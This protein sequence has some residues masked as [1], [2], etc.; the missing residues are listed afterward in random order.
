M[1]ILILSWQNIYLPLAVEY[2]KRLVIE[3][4]VSIFKY[5]YYFVYPGYTSANGWCQSWYLIA[6]L[7]GLP[8]FMGIYKIC[9]KKV[10]LLILVCSV[11][12]IYYI[13][14]NEFSFLTHLPVWG[15]L[16]FPRL[17]I[18]ILIG[19]ILSKNISKIEKFNISR[20][21]LY[22]IIFFCMFM[23]ENYLVKVNG[24]LINSE[25][26][27]T[28]VPTSIALVL[29]SLKYVPTIKMNVIKVRNCS[30]FIYCAQKYPLQVFLK[31]MKVFYLNTF[32]EHIV[33][34]GSVCVISIFLF[35]IYYHFNKK[36]K[37]L[38]YLV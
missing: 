13:L 15:T 25:E 38:E 27:I 37:F 35:L 9:F 14:A 28:T 8:V 26:V 2:F 32:L 6:M 34:F 20:V 4:N 19:F 29:F 12:E 33:L 5:I 36:Y 24:G 22:L 21:L 18:Y 3:G 23:L 16:Y 1:G 17:L 7:M 10:N 31:I 30:T 11:I